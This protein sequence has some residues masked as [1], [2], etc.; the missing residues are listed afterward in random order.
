MNLRQIDTR[1]LVQD[2]THIKAYGVRLDRAVPRLRQGSAWACLLR[3][4]R[5]EHR[6]DLRIALVDP[7]LVEVVE[8]QCL[9][10]AKT[11]SGW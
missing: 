7:G 11:C 1:Q 2:W 4:E 5:S 8:R 3:G 9:V 10:S 6:L